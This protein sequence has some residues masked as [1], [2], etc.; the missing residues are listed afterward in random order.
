MMDLL[1]RKL[2]PILPDAW[3][4]IDDE[5]RRALQVGLAGR[6]LVDFDGPHGWGHASVSTGRVDLLGTDVVPGVSA[7]IRRVLPIAEL[8]TPVK[9]LIAELDSV[10]RGADNPDL[11]PVSLAAEKI[12]HAE[13]MAIFHGWPAARIAGIIGASSHPKISIASLHDYP[14][15]ILEAKD[16]LRAANIG[17]PYAL[18]VGTRVYDELFAA[19]E[20]GYPLVKRI[21][22]QIVERIVRA[23]AIEGAV[24]LS[25]RG[26]DYRLSVGQDFSIGYVSSDRYEV[27]LF[28][29]ETFTFHVIEPAA[30]VHLVRA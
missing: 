30:A 24:L 14:Q 8:R 3:A 16:L 20:E 18:A 26:G 29:C 12:A 11:Q 1:K 4:L 15:R 17:G 2:S 5:A 27:E 13:D 21:E 25:T 22:K 23:P 7:G 10:T 28:L 9:L 19:T 6:K